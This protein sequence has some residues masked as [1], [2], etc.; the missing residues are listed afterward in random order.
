MFGRRP[1]NF[2]GRR[3]EEF[4]GF[5]LGLLRHLLQLGLGRLQRCGPVRGPAALL[6]R[7]RGS[8]AGAALTVLL[9]RLGAWWLVLRDARGAK[10]GGGFLCIYVWL[11]VGH[12]FPGV[13]G[14]VLL[15]GP[16]GALVV[17]SLPVGRGRAG[18]GQWLLGQLVRGSERVSVGW[19]A[20]VGVR[21]VVMAFGFH[22]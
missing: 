21:R 8:R 15:G 14:S 1:G 20:V 12:G 17:Q 3:P 11:W 19:G 6:F 9:G 13:H 2:L 18:R 16:V 7:S 4:L 10:C 22:V 5:R